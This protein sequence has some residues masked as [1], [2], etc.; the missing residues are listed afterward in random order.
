MELLSG[1]LW[2][3]TNTLFLSAVFPERPAYIYVEAILLQLRSLFSTHNSQSQLHTHADCGV[4]QA[5]RWES[6]DSRPQ[7]CCR[8]LRVFCP[9]GIGDLLLFSSKEIL[10]FY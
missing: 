7:R 9:D 2:E 10:Y 3:L 5:T 4:A 8:K 6:W 1:V